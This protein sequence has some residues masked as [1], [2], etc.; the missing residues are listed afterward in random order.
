MYLVN[1]FKNGVIQH[2]EFTTRETAVAFCHM[3]RRLHN[4][5]LTAEME[6]LA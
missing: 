5:G 1:I 6:E 4:T 2:T 3:I